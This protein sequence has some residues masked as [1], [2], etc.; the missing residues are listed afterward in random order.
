[1]TPLS[2]ALT[3]AQR[4]AIATLEK[5]YVAGLIEP[6]ALASAMEACGIT[7]AVD[8][9][10]LLA[11]LDVL[12][13]WGVAAP[14]MTERVAREN[15]EPKKATE[16]QVKYALDLLARGNHSLDESEVRCLTFERASELI[17]SLKSGSYQAAEWE[18]PF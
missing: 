3:A 12:R 14:T 13:E 1:V 4:H 18:V 2:D 9:S 17:D 6:E 8:R 15:G 11:S 5:A 10:F 16:G 7:D